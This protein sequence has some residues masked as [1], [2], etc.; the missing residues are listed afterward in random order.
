MRD[1]ILKQPSVPKPSSP[2]T[3]G[4]ASSKYPRLP[5]RNK[6]AQQ[7]IRA[8]KEKPGLAGIRVD[9]MFNVSGV[10]KGTG[11]GPAIAFAAHTDTVFPEGTPIL[12]SRKGDT[13]T[14]P[15]PATTPQT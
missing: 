6:P 13:L 8:E 3:N 1:N 12:V 11:G 4:F 14:A 9:D 7:Y 2:L 5:A 15:E 10:R